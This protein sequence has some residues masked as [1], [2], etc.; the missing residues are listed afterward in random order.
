MKWIRN[1]NIL[2]RV[3]LGK[4]Q[5]QLTGSSDRVTSSDNSSSSTN[6][7]HHLSLGGVTQSVIK[8]AVKSSAA[9]LSPPAAATA[10]NVPLLS[11][12]IVAQLN[13]LLFSIHGLADKCIEAKVRARAGE[14]SFKGAAA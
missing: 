4:M 14:L 2:T 8:S 5:Q 12:Q 9:G 13:A 10:S 7:I 11:G 1:R 6:N 3:I